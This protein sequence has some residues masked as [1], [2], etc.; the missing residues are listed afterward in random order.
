MFLF[1]LFLPVTVTAFPAI[2]YSDGNGQQ[3]TLDASK[4]KLTALHFW[5]TWCKPCIEELPQVNNTQKKYAD[6]DFK[7]IA[8]SLDGKNID[9]VKEFYSANKIDSLE[10]F[11]DSDMSAFRQLKIRGLPTTVFINSAG[12]EIAT[13][14]GTVNWENEETTDFIERQLDQ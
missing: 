3:H 2:I 13:V 7:V 12:K 11:L 14:P 10:L 5:A 6:K 9:K 4:H 8:L 1:A